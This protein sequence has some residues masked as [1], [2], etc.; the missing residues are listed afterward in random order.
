VGIEDLILCSG[1]V[2]SWRADGANRRGPYIMHFISRPLVP[3]V[4]RLL[5]CK[6]RV[7][8]EVLGTLVSGDLDVCFSEELLRGG[9]SFLE[10][11]SNESPV[12]GPW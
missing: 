10:D 3:M 4:V 8:N 2:A 5:G 12:I 1:V 7:A 6:L 9:W 11:G